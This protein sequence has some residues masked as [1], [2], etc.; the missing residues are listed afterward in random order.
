MAYA[1]ERTQAAISPASAV[2]L[3]GGAGDVAATGSAITDAAQLN[4][5][6]NVVSAADGTKGV[7]LT[8]GQPG[9]EVWVHNNAGSNLKVYPQSSAAKIVISGTSTGVAGAAVTVAANKGAIF[10]CQSSTQWLAILSA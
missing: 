8:G 10:K 1:K 2:A 9:D 7:A 4:A 6:I 5:S 3:G